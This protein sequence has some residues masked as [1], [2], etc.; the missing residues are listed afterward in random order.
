[1]AWVL[2]A[3]ASRAGAQSLQ[4]VLS[5]GSVAMDAEESSG[6]LRAEGLQP[7]VAGRGESPP[8]KPAKSGFPA[9]IP[10]S[11]QTNGRCPTAITA[12]ASTPAPQPPS[13]QATCSRHVGRG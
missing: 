4:L 6:Q 3:A 7:A 11:G 9:V 2:I 10:S 12:T 5:T 1:M 8:R 13:G